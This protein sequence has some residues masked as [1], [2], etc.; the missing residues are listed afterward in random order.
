MSEEDEADFGVSVADDGGVL[1][2]P[3]ALADGDGFWT[4]RKFPDGRWVFAADSDEK[5]GE[6]SASAVDL[7]NDFAPVADAKTVSTLLNEAQA[8]FKSRSPY[9]PRFRFL[10]FFA[11]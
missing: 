9:N 5:V 6:A 7:M 4:A 8:A 3:D 2:W 10:V 11:R 1:I